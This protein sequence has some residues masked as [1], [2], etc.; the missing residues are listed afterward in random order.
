MP[1]NDHRWRRTMNLFTPAT[2][3]MR[4]DPRF[5]ELC[6]GIGLSDYWARRGKQPDYQLPRA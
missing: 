2:A 5:I 3:A 1:I 4:A 6:D